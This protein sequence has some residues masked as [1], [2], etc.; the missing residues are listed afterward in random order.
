[1]NRRLLTVLSACVLLASCGSP[2]DSLAFKAPPNWTAT[3]GLFGRAQ[4]WINNG[5]F[6]ALI[7]GDKNMTFDDA[8]KSAP[9]VNDTKSTLTSKTITLCGTQKAQYFVGTGQSTRNGKTQRNVVEGTFTQIGNDRFVAF[10]VRPAA[11]QPDAAAEN[12]IHSVCPK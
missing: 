11:V 7:R 1:M 4:I 8:A 10:Y 3:P 5:Q 9:N 12:A 6:V 2:A